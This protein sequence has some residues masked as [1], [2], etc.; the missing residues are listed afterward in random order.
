MS[1]TNL[2][3]KIYLVAGQIP[4]GKVATYGDLA[5]VVGGGCTARVVG[6]AL[7]AL[8]AAQAAAVPWQR[9]IA[10]DGAISTRGLRQAD[11]LRAEGI[12]FDEQGRVRIVRHHWRGP[13]PAWAAAHGCNLLPPHDEPEQ[14]RLL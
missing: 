5:V 3:A 14:L 7:A 4:P 13:D 11:L 9:V 10:K 12:S 8:P 6:E 1:D 2:Y